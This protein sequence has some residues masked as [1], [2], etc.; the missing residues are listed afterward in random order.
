M[1][2]YAIILLQTKIKLNLH[3]PVQIVFANV[4]YNLS[5]QK[6]KS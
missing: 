5:N 2:L 3:F 4:P 6:L 1:S